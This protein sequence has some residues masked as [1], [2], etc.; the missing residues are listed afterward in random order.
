M[1]VSCRLT[2]AANAV[3]RESIDTQENNQ[4]NN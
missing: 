1:R 2:D 4:N 3:L